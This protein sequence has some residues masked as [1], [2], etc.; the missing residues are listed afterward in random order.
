KEKKCVEVNPQQ[1]EVYRRIVDMCLDGKS[2]NDI[3]IALRRDG[4]KAKLALFS[5]TVVGQILKNPCYYSGR[6]LR[7]THVF[8]GNVK[9]EEMKPA[10]QHFEL[11]MPRL[12]DKLTWDR[13]QEKIAFN[14]VKTKRT[15]NPNF[16]L[17]NVLKCG[18]CGGVI[19]PKSIRGRFDY[20][21][22][23]WAG[24]GK[25]NLEAAGKK[26]CCL[27]NLQA[28]ELQDRVM[29]HLL[30]FLTFGG[31]II[32]GKYAPSKI[33]K[34]LGPQKF[35]DKTKSLSEQLAQM[36]RALGRKTT[37]RENLFAMLEEPGF[38]RSLFAA[39]MEKIQTE[40]QT[41]EAHIADTGQKL[42]DLDRVR[43]NH[44]EMIRFVK[45]NQKWLRGIAEKITG[46]EP[47]EKQKLIEA[48]LDGKIV[49]EYDEETKTWVTMPP[50]FRFNPDALQALVDEN[51]F[52]KVYN[53]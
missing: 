9:T 30:H 41:L 50:P 24:A 12:A 21:T 38:D 26:K 27:P 48:M 18:E 2:Y 37:A 8:K 3:T 31:F 6:L 53:H 32:A 4:I 34:M 17:R 7:N 40:I 42:S 10:D 46:L 51:G 44:Q 49:V 29:Y 33:E 52:D 25:K 22:C 16:W 13:V 19:K 35:D 14:K 20:Y 11:K 5:A 43:A 1:A 23:F 15:K 39:Q 28:Q 47:Q 45:G 36:K